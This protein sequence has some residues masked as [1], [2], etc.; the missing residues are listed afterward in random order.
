M[1]L[2]ESTSPLVEI[3]LCHLLTLF[4]IGYSNNK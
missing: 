1:Q 3:D 2:I 4:V